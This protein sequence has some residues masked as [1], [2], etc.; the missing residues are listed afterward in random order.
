[1]QW[2]SLFAFEDTGENLEA[3][4]GKL[5]AAHRADPLVR[6]P[7]ELIMV[8]RVLMVQTG[9]VARINPTWSMPELIEKRLAEGA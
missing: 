2:A 1:M 4:W 7:E 9:L 5:M 8:G 3:A 6:I